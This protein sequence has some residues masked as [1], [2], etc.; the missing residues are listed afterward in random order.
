MDTQGLW[1]DAVD[2]FGFSATTGS[3]AVIALFQ[4]SLLHV[5]YAGDSSAII[6]LKNGTWCD[7]VIPHKPVYDVMR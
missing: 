1:I 2:R 7:F 5:A 3:T 4:E 6:F